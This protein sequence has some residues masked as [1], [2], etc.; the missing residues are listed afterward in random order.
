MS[1]IRRVEVN[2]FWADSTIVEA[3]DFVYIAYCMGAEGEPVEKQMDA[4]FLLLE[5]RLN[6]VG[7]GLDA[8]VQMDCLF[9]NIEDLHLLPDAIRA[10]FGDKYPTR[11]AFTSA[12]IREGILFQVDAVAYK[13]AAK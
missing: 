9:K 5:K 7:L 4:T 10:R 2:E 1:E 11:K 3:G 13:G 8:V 12:F 6:K